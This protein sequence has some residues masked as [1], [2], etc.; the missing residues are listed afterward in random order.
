[1]SLSARKSERSCDQGRFP[2]ASRTRAAH[3]LQVGDSRGAGAVASSRLRR[4]RAPLSHRTRPRRARARAHAQVWLSGASAAVRR[5][6][7]PP[8]PAFIGKTVRQRAARGSE[9]PRHAPAAAL[10]STA[11]DVF[12][13]LCKAHLGGEAVLSRPFLFRRQHGRE[14]ERTPLA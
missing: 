8:A 11:Q 3:A 1:M 10:P 5:A 6:F 7:P 2:R 9:L 4:A 14:R 12:E 13:G